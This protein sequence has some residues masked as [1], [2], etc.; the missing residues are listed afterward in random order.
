MTNKNL[1]MQNVNGDRVVMKWRTVDGTNGYQ[2]KFL[3]AKVDK[4]S[5]DGDVVMKW[6]T[7]EDMNGRKCTFLVPYNQI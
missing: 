7:V 3:S 2:Y 4:D 6:H 5:D 1:Q